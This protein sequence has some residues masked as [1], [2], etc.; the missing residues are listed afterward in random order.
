MNRFKSLPEQ[1]QFLC[2]ILYSGGIPC[3]LTLILVILDHVESVPDNLQ[4]NVGSDNC[5]LNRKQIEYTR[6]IIQ[7]C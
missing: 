2:Y 6:K 1:K 3:L 7:Q 5:F 4:P